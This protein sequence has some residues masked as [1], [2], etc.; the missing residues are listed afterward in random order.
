MFL[1]VSKARPGMGCGGA[2]LA[3]LDRLTADSAVI[4]RAGPPQADRRH[5]ARHIKAP[6]AAHRPAG[7]M[8]VK[9]QVVNEYLLLHKFTVFPLHS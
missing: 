3:L 8:D 7:T 5:G 9:G 1:Q 2:G 4:S 6:T